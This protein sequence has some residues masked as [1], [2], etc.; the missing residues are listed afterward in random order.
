M[1]RCIDLLTVCIAKRR[2]TQDCRPGEGRDPSLR[3]RYD[4][5]NW[6]PACAGATAL[7]FSL[8]APAFAQE[9]FPGIARP[10]PPAEIAAWDIDVR[11]D[12]KGLPKGA[13]SVALG[14]KVWDEKCATCHGT[15][16]ESNEVFPPIVGGTTAAD[17]K[18][19]RAK[20]LTEGVGR[21]TLMK[22]SS[23]SAIWD[24]IHRAMPWD[25]PKSLTTDE[26]YASVA[27]ILHLGDIVP[28]DFVLSDANIRLA[29][30][31]LP[32]RNGKVKY[33]PLWD[34]RGKGDVTNVAC[35]KNCPVSAI[36]A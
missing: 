22:L 11:P 21:T 24:Y 31:R 16:G 6:A 18:T 4:Y 13:G 14:Q 5:R 33:E 26:V 27:Y 34:V 32:N 36:L 1:F 7:W 25:R 19:G 12:F 35:M 10:A 8:T 9:K 17:I 28:A 3:D 2:N 30:Q 23:L 29:E 15:F 20:A